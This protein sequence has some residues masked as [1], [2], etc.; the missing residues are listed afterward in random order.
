M[1]V[2]LLVLPYLL[3]AGYLAALACTLAIALGIIAAFNYYI[4]VARDQ[5]FGRR[6]GEMAAL[7]LAVAGLSFLIG[8]LVRGLGIA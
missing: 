2:I 4:A 5:P 1:T 3:L 7:S 8:F 6:F